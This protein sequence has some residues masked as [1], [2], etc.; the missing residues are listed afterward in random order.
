MDRY[1]SFKSYQGLVRWTR[2]LVWYNNHVSNLG[3]QRY[4]SKYSHKQEPFVYTSTPEMYETE[5][6]PKLYPEFVANEKTNK[7]QWFNMILCDAGSFTIKNRSFFDKTTPTIE[8]KIKNS[9]LLGETEVTQEL[10]EFVMGANANPSEYQ[11]DKQNPVEN[12]SWEKVINFCNK[13]S[14][15]QNLTPCYAKVDDGTDR[16]KNIWIWKAQANGYRL[17]TTHEAQYA[18]KAGTDNQWA[19]TNQLADLPKYAWFDENSNHSTQPVARKLPNEWGL[20]DM[21]GNV[22]ELR[23]GYKEARWWGGSFV[24]NAED[25][26]FESQQNNDFLP[27]I[28]VPTIGFRIARTFGA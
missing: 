14:E 2:D 4:A 19:G 25:L 13:L 28:P 23:W 9:F 10:Y 7:T 20:Y 17:P 24:C 22:N 8:I 18:A 3:K 5:Y 12:I 6:S 1:S 15:L 21:N 26:M 27:R 16:Q 11:N